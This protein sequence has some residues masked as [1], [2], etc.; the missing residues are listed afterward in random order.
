MSGPIAQNQSCLGFC[1]RA[2]KKVGRYFQ[3]FGFT[4][5][6]SAA[7]SGGH[8][9]C[10]VAVSQTLSFA[11][12]ITDSGLSLEVGKD[13]VNLIVGNHRVTIVRIAAFRTQSLCVSAHGLDKIHGEANIVE[14]WKQLGDD[15]ESCR[16]P[17]DDII[18]GIDGNCRIA[19]QAG[20]NDEVVGSLVT[21]A[22]VV[23]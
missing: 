21:G 12:P 22:A 14:Y 15:L 2:Q 3:E 23:G 18:C 7:D 10:M 13:D 1:A 4:L 5:A 6:Q 8:G 9:G 16:D 17:C 11:D 19:F 20:R